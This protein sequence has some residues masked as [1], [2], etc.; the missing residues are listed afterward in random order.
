MKLLP[1]HVYEGEANIASSKLNM[2][3]GV[4]S[5]LIK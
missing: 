2:T 4:G 5:G 1:K 3:Q